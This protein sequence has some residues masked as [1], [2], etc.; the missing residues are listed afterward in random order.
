MTNEIY[1]LFAD[2]KPLPKGTRIKTTIGGVPTGGTHE[3]PDHVLESANKCP[4]HMSDYVPFWILGWRD[5]HDDLLLTPNDPKL[6]H[7][8]GR[9]APQAR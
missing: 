1:N 7:A 9:V 2:N 8:D 4:N 6:S 5:L 3:L